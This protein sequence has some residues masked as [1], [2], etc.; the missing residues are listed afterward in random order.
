M[1]VTFD[2]WLQN[3]LTFSGGV[4]GDV[5][6]WREHLLVRVVAKAHSGPVSTMYTTLRDGLIVTGGKE[7]P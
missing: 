7:R 1:S 6:V 4:N 2:P 5:F 3:Q